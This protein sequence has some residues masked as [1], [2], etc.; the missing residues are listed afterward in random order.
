VIV[1]CLA[2]F[3]VQAQCLN[4]ESD[5][6]ELVGTIYSKVFAGPPNY[7]SIKAG[8]AKETAT[9][10]KLKAAICTRSDGAANSFNVAESNVT[11]IQLVIG[12]A[13]FWKA[14]RQNRGRSF[15]VKGSL[16]HSHTGHHRTRVL[17]TVSDLKAL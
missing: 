1:V 6:I 13:E 12:E 17:L 9:I 11:R 4:Y 3:S 14:I 16:F 8:D 15:R 2:A 10:L 5:T 7:E